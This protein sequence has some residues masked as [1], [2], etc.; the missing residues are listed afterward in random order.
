MFPSDKKD[1]VM[2][3]RHEIKLNYHILP[4]VCNHRFRRFVQFDIFDATK[5][6][7]SVQ[8]ITITN[9][10]AGK[11]TTREF[12]IRCDNHGAISHGGELHK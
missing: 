2:S 6:R 10:Q 12:D 5:L 4:E 9:S 3:H 11:T 7:R 8:Q 1:T